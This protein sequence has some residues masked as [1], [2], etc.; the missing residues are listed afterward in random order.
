MEK[1]FRY[2]RICNDPSI[3]AELTKWVNYRFDDGELE[4]L[5][6]TDDSEVSFKFNAKTKKSVSKVGKG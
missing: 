3:N 2:Q 6:F 1:L 4:E 5:G